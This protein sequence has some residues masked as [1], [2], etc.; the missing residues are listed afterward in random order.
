MDIQVKAKT[1]VVVICSLCFISARAQSI[2]I[3][4]LTNVETNQLL[5][6]IEK[7]EIKNG[8]K[9]RL[10]LFIVNNGSG[11]AHLPES[12]EVSHSLLISVSEYDE[13]RKVNVFRAGPFFNPQII[14]SKDLD[15]KFIISFQHG[16]YNNRR[17]GSLKIALNEIKY[18]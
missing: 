16:L 17:N 14:S 7:L 5:S 6:S 10:S 15:E 13:D 12:D 3:T 18:E 4:Q 8:D 2:E 11:S 1:L 9:L